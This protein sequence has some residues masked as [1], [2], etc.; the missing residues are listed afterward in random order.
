MANLTLAR[1]HNIQQNQSTASPSTVA[2]LKRKFSVAGVSFLACRMSRESFS[3]LGASEVRLLISSLVFSDRS[4]I[5]SV[6]YL[7]RFT[8]WIDVVHPLLNYFFIKTEEHNPLLEATEVRSHYDVS[9]YVPTGWP[10][11]A[12]SP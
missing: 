7:G 10:W 6:G 1:T 12:V 9:E 4:C 3:P 8:I 5:I 2:K 11:L